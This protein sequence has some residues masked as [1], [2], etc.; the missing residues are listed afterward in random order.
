VEL[1]GRG[2]DPGQVAAGALRYARERLGLDPRAAADG[3]ARPEA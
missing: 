3:P 1:D 2:E